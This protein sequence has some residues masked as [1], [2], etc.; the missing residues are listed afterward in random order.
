MWILGISYMVQFCVEA[1]IIISYDQLV[2]AR[3]LSQMIESF[4]EIADLVGV[5]IWCYTS[6]SSWFKGDLGR[7]AINNSFLVD[8]LLWT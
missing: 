6:A 5:V 2:L 8:W 4:A 1:G 3:I 7:T